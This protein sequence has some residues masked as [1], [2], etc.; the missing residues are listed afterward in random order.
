MTAAPLRGRLV[1]SSFVADI[2][3]GLPFY[4]APPPAV[5]AQLDQCAERIEE[6]LGPASGLRSVADMA[7]L[8]VLTR[9]GFTVTARE[10]D[11]TEC[12]I[13]T[14][15]GGA[16][17]PLVA[18]V[19][20]G[21]PLDRRWRTVV[22][23]AIANDT[24]WCLSCNGQSLRLID[25]RRT[26]SRRYLEFDLITALKQ[27]DMQ[28]VIWT[29][30]RAEALTAVPGPLDEAIARSVR[31]GTNVCKALGAGVL[32]ALALLL[33]TLHGRHA[34][35]QPPAVLFE[36]SLTVLYR[37]LFLLFAEARL[38]VPVW[39]PV[40]RDRYSL[41]AIV[42][43]LL[44]GR[45]YRGLWPALQ[46]IA[47]LA[48]AGC[49]AGEL[50]VTAFNGRL[51][52]PAQAA[53]FDR[54]PIADGTMRAAILAVS[55][56]TGTAGAARTRI[57][58]RDLDVEQLG[59]VYEQV[60][61]YEPGTREVPLVRTRDLRKASGA[62]YTPR[63]VT[64]YLV[65]RALAPLVHQR[66][67]DQILALRIVDP[68]MG[69]GAF[70][71]AACRYLARAIEDALIDEGRWHAGDVTA[72]DRAAL[73]REIAS[74][75]LYGVDLNPM[76]VQLG[77]LSLWLATLAADRPLSFLDHHLVCGD[78]LIGA[79]PADVQRQPGRDYGRS[80]R[81]QPLPLFDDAELATTLAGAVRVRERLALEP[82]DSAAVVREK[83]RT[84]AALTT[85]G[86][87]MG[88]W[89]R[90]LDLWCGSW[91]SDGEGRLGRATF[92]DLVQQIRHDA[93]TLPRRASDS[94]LA[95]AADTAVRHRFLHWPLA[96]P[97][98][99]AGGGFDAVIG[100]PPWDMVRGDSGAGETR[101]SRQREARDAV[102]FFRESGIYAVDARAHVNRYQLFVER[103]L[104]LLT[105]GGRLGLV[106]PS[107]VVS[108]AGA[109]PLR[110]HLFDRANVDSVTGL[111]NRSGIF[112]I[113]RSVRFALVT[114]TSG[115]PT[116]RV[117]CRFGIG[118]LDRL[119]G[120]DATPLHLTRHF[121]A[122][123]S[124]PEDLGIPELASIEDLRIVERLA[125]HIPWLSA[126]SGWGA[127]F[128]REL[129]A[130]DD[131]GAFV[132]RSGNP[133]SRPVVAGKQIG[134]FRVDLR[135]CLQEVPA[136]HAAAAR[137]PR[138]I[139]LVYRD[140]ASAT[141]RVTLIAALIPAHAITTHTLFCLKTPLPL[142]HQEVLCAL[143]NSFVANY[144]IRLR[145]NTH[146]TASLMSRLPVPFVR[147]GDQA[148]EQLRTL[149]HTLMTAADVEA[150][151]EYAALQALAAR[152]YGLSTTEFEHILSTFP[153]IPESVRRA[154]ARRYEQ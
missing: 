74:R 92:G 120:E 110:R 121:L 64:A 147:P 103:A 100:N 39:H 140:V 93:G 73:R 24:G 134:P 71:V 142:A 131:R 62:F 28:A 136:G 66:T 144:L 21:E 83:E 113:H 95:A 152:V 124:G 32:D 30:L 88:R 17:G 89:I 58:Y 141:N 82:D 112:P 91:F 38:L 63:V 79:S 57:A 115:Q 111:D 116:S 126:E 31:H 11:T 108:D 122:R 125:A 40:Y 12:R 29:L 153:L 42:T 10:E 61:D 65:R 7:V 98:A 43:S 102:A 45:T 101:A 1:S 26:W 9:L 67:A 46:A 49:R 149:T 15:A 151:P 146:V 145:V 53:T 130:T 123:L 118:D 50:K 14:A 52:S 105:P 37:V 84:L 34:A 22:H 4:Q 35:K 128:G 109:A 139:R 114:A 5:R 106:L 127:R 129:N 132:P 19:P 41:D 6:L 77:R 107:G 148:F 25:G 2:L 133:G 54:T 96:F 27:R 87:A 80:R 75:C 97:E 23:A 117:E 70:L 76:A 20:F 56:V 55:S 44:A 68:A 99:F 81:S 59:A 135:D 90:V 104:Q 36:H 137:A 16:T 3:P 51:F 69:S 150:A 47:R 78:S 154:A 85:G 48:H 72:A 8:P 143:L 13:H 119:D 86:T 138:R 94:L 60:L 33:A 18:V